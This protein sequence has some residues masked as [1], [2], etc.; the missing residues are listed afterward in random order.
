MSSLISIVNLTKKMKAFKIPLK[1]SDTECK[2]Y[3]E[4]LMPVECRIGADWNGLFQCSTGENVKIRWVSTFNNEDGWFEEELDS[5][6]QRLYNWSFSRV[7][8]SWI[9]RLGRVEG[10]WDLIKLYKVEND[11]RN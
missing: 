3:C 8:S 1:Y 7:R 5:I 4:A 11:G 2:G 9:A 10:Y 6:S